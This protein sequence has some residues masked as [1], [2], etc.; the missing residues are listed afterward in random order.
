[1]TPPPPPSAGRPK[2][3][4]QS[5]REP[6]EML[7]QTNSSSSS[8]SCTAVAIVEQSTRSCSSRQADGRTDWQT[9][10]R[11]DKQTERHLSLAANKK[12]SSSDYDYDSDSDSGHVLAA[13]E[14]QLVSQGATRVPQRRRLQGALALGLPLPLGGSSLGRL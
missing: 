8:S 7:P 2:M 3:L 12:D 4:T 14:R 13:V 5:S 1:M 10:G 6:Q 11:T 9:D